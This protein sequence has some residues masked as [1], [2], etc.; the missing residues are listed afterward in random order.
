[1]RS[2]SCGMFADLCPNELH[3]VEFRSARR[4]VVHMQTQLCCDKI[5]HDIAFMDGVIVPHQDDLSL[6]PP[7]QLLQEFY[8]LLTAQT[9]LV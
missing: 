1:M 7:E 3:R 6:N 2:K 5:F 8:V 9:M 4:E